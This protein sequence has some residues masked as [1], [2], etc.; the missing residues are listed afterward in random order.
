M[1][2]SMIEKKTAIQ[3]SRSGGESLGRNAWEQTT[4]GSVRDDLPFGEK[5]DRGSEAESKGVHQPI[6]QES[7]GLPGGL[8]LK[9][10]YRK[11]EWVF[12]SAQNK[13]NKGS[14]NCLRVSTPMGTIQNKVQP[15]E[16]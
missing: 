12:C 3:I 15:S 7:A 8:F 5:I 2:Y 13:Y 4:R 9:A 1:E 11:R 6:P 10:A 16:T 14:W